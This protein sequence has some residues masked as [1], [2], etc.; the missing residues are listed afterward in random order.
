MEGRECAVNIVQE[1]GERTI[2]GRLAR[3]HHIVARAEIGVFDFRGERGLE[4]AADTIPRHR[5]PDLLGDRETEAGPLAV[6]G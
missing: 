2:E 1:V 5:V 3:D 6:L 4:P